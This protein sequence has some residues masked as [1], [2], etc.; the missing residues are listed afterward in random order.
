M[1][2]FFVPTKKISFLPNKQKK[3][4]SL[5]TQNT[6]QTSHTNLSS[7]FRNRHGVREG[8]RTGKSTKANGGGNR[9]YLIESYFEKMCVN[10]PDDEGPF[11]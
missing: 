7:S 9:N 2:L 11:F 4:H 5:L 8:Q 6:S 10:A 3:S 1:N